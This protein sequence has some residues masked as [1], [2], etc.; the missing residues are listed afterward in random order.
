LAKI[1]R[2]MIDELDIKAKSFL[3]AKLGS[4]A[5]GD[6]KEVK[7]AVKELWFTKVAFYDNGGV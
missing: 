1:R 7:K 5:Y 3:F 6:T 2:V 4:I